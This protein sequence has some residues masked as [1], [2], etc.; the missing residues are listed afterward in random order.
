[1][2]V[3]PGLVDI[4]Q[5]PLYDTV[6]VAENAAVGNP[7]QFFVTPIG[8]TKQR[9]QTNLTQAQR[10]EA[11]RSFKIHAVRLWWQEN[12]LIADIYSLMQNYCLVLIVGEKEYQ[13]GPLWYFP[14]GGGVVRSAVSTT[15]TNTTLAALH[16][17]V[18]DARA[19]NVIGAP[20]VIGIEQGENFRVELQGTSFTTTAAGSGGTGLR[21]M[22]LLD[23][24]LSRQ[25]Q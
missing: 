25:V 24:I 19:I 16:N 6:I 7:V 9:N 11:P 21:L 2:A 5:I 13:I 22:C 14:A 20:Y 23:G 10:L 1:M 15:V 3:A 17:G 12:A 4:Q 18:P 8:G